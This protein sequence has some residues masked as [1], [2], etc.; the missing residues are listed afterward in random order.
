[1][2]T[3]SISQFKIDIGTHPTRNEVFPRRKG[4]FDK[5]ETFFNVSDDAPYD[6]TIT[7]RDDASVHWF[8]I[9]EFGYWTYQPF[10]W[11]VRLLDE[12]IKE[13]KEIYLHCHAGAH[14]SPMMAYLYIRSLGFS[15]EE[16]Y[17]KFAESNTLGERTNWLE[18]T[19]QHD[20]EY[21]RIPSD[22]VEFMQDVRANKD[23]SM[24]SVMKKRGVMDLPQKTIDKRGTRKPVGEAQIALEKK[25][26]FS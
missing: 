17:A 9:N 15:P 20:I 12:A 3:Y 2:I 4:E 8:P 25:G 13:N 22:V 7:W 26:L 16:S 23:L 1:M 5:Y 14:R 10:Y 21:G 24:M 6:N 18:E 19:F 11:L